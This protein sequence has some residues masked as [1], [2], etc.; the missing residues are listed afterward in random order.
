MTPFFKKLRVNQLEERETFQQ[1]H[2]RE[3]AAV[4]AKCFLASREQE[5]NYETQTDV[6]QRATL[7]CVIGPSSNCYS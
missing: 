5:E 1:R 7:G 4:G 2:G 3:H 6:Q